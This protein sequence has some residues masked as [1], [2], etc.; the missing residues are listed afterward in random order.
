M[1]QLM[2]SDP[3]LPAQIDLDTLFLV[4]DSGFTSVSGFPHVLLQR[5][6]IPLFLSVLI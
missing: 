4:Y 2:K 5:I 1:L 6:V 3:K